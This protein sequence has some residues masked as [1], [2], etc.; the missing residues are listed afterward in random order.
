VKHVFRYD[1]SPLFARLDDAHKAIPVLDETTHS[2]RFVDAPRCY[3]VPL[4]LYLECG[5]ETWEEDAT[6]VMHKRGLDRIER[7]DREPMDSDPSLADVGLEP[8]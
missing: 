7:E 6:L 4:K 3:R 8:N 1:M 5:D 2:V